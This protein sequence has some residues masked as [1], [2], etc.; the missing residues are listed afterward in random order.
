M[1][2]KIMSIRIEISCAFCS[3]KLVNDIAD[4][5]W[6]VRYGNIGEDGFCPK[7]AIVEDFF[8]DQ[9]P[10]CIAG[11]GDCSLYRG[12]MYS[13]LELTDED[14]IS[15][16][17]GI[18]PKRGNGTFGIDRDG[19]HDLDISERASSKSGLALVDA[20]KEYSKKYH[21]GES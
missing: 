16:E 12:F 13:K 15:L 10:G 17:R 19:L 9:C 4:N 5:G 18:C 8:K 7:H 2:R 21:K 3:K 14:F 6:N 1:R 11:W 20:I